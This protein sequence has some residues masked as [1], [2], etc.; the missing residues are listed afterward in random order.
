MIR[1]PMGRVIFPSEDTDLS[2]ELSAV[3][4]GD[5]VDGL[6]VPAR[7]AAMWPS[8]KRFGQHFGFA[9]G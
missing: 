9:S 8:I 2:D 5:E 6:A 3:V 1:P 4:V 7:S